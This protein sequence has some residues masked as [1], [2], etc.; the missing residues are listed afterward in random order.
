MKIYAPLII[1]LMF[2]MT[3]NTQVDTIVYL[4]GKKILF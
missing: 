2:F 4:N 3:S 1:T